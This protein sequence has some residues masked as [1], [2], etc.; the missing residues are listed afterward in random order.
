[1]NIATLE[2]LPIEVNQALDLILSGNTLPFSQ[3]GLEFK[4]RERALPVK[5][6]KYYK[7]YTVLTPNSITRGTRRLVLGKGKEMYYTEDHYSSFTAI[8]H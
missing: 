3:D 8:S 5:K 4:N 7:E 6:P 1:M 2:S